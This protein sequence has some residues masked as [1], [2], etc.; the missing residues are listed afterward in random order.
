ME[1]RMDS[2][3]AE[4]VSDRHVDGQDTTMGHMARTV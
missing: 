1:N 4:K 2:M 3:K